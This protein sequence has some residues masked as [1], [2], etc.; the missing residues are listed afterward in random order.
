MIA[1]WVW[2]V[3][4][5]K[6][7][8]RSVAGPLKVIPETFTPSRFTTT[9]VLAIPGEEVTTKCTVLVNWNR[10]VPSGAKLLTNGAG[11][12]FGSAGKNM[13]KFWLWPPPLTVTLSVFSEPS[14]VNCTRAPPVLR[15]GNQPYLSQLPVE[16]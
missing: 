12:R 8:F 7:T 4:T 10:L 11:T 1:V 3:C 15:T 13:K 16:L 6:L 5:G 14:P 9:P 2:F